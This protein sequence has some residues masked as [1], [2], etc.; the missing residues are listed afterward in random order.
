MISEVEM[1]NKLQL[2][3]ILPDSNTVLAK[4]FGDFQPF[5]TD[6]TIVSFVKCKHDSNMKTTA[7]V[8]CCN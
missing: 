2:F 6:L 4:Q 8:L 7:Q 1:V 3:Y 5:N